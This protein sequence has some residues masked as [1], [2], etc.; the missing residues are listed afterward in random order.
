ME[1]GGGVSF[2]GDESSKTARGDRSKPG[3]WSENH[4][5][6]DAILLLYRTP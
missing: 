6:V 4:H 5:T 1:N 3:E 2:Q